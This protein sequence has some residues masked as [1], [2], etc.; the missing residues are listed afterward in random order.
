M[1]ESVKI[2]GAGLLRANAKRAAA[3]TPITTTRTSHAGIASS[4]AT[5]RSRNSR[6]RFPAGAVAEPF[7]RAFS[8][9]RSVARNVDLLT[10]ETAFEQREP[11]REDAI[12]V[13]ELRDHG[14][15]M[16]EQQQDEERGQHEQ[17]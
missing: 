5:A 1:S 12:L 4:Q 13:G 7:R 15:V 6:P 16:Q 17:G 11:L 10:A 9:R 14:R 8:S 2:H 3:E